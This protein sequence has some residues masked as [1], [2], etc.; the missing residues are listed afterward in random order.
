MLLEGHHWHCLDVSANGRYTGRVPIYEYRCEHGHQ[1]EVIQRFSDDPLV[2]CNECGAPVRK[3][4]TAPAIHFKGSGFHN[5][6][7]A[8]RNGSKSGV[9]T[10]GSSGDGGSGGE[11]SRSETGSTAAG[12]GESTSTSTSTSATSSSPAS[13]STP[14]PAK[15]D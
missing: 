15:R 13:S 10:G 3:I 8:R 6:D 11:G 9:E 14:P 7:Y 1:F 12:K 5:T 4:L 2:T